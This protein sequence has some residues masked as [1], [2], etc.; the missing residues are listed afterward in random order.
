MCKAVYERQSLAGRDESPTADCE[1]AR[2][3]RMALSQAA[4]KDKITEEFGRMRYESMVSSSTMQTLKEGLRSWVQDAQD[5]LLNELQPH[6]SPNSG[7]DVAALL[8]SHLSWLQ[9]IETDATEASNH[10]ALLGRAFT[11]PVA[12]RLG[13]HRQSV[14][15]AEGM[16]HSTK[17]IT[18]YCFDIPLIPQIQ[19]LIEHDPAAWAQIQS[20]SEEWSQVREASTDIS[21]ITDGKIFREHEKLGVNSGSIVCPDLGGNRLKLAFKAYYDEIETANPLGFARGVHSI[22]CTYVSLINLDKET[23]NRLEYTFVVTLVLNSSVKRYGAEKVFGG[24][25]VRG[26]SGELQ[27]D[28]ESTSLGAQMRTFDKGVKFSVPNASAF[29]GY[30]WQ[31]AHGWMVLFSADFPAAGKMLPTSQSTAAHKPCRGCLWDRTSKHAYKPASFFRACPWKVRTLQQVA[32]TI[33]KA[34]K[35]DTKVARTTELRADGLYSFT[36]ALH[37]EIFPFFQPFKGCP[38]DAMHAEFSSGTCNSEAA[39]LLYL[40]ITREKWF[41]VDQL[42]VAIEKF[43]WPEGH[44]PPSIWEAVTKGQKGG[45][46]AADA[47][48]RYSGAQTMRFTLSSIELLSPLVQDET[49]PA[50][51]SW[52]AHVNYVKLLVSHSF[53]LNS[54]KKLDQLVQQHHKL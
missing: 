47:N 23:R 16:E 25:T 40:L 13:T 52:V 39:Q 54:V 21:D 49:H 38:Q 20:S 45:L 26:D 50:W 29:D 43:D 31:V 6:I 33:Q 17:Q 51:L 41:S 10:R 37:P 24:V 53:T 11:E 36:Y 27:F 4:M 44:Q 8:K 3:A 2:E 9:G 7:L 18:D 46:P 15:D 42:N 30:R 48:L 28:E 5:G 32:Q 34:M 12:R 22:G 14:K 1:G 35:H 19:A